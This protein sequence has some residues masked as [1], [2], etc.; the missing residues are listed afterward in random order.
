MLCL[1]T[2]RER[3]DPEKHLELRNLSIPMKL[4]EIP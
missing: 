2:V 3:K 4:T 1:Q